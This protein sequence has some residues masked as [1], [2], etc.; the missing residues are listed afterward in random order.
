MTTR[1]T[2][3]TLAIAALLVLLLPRW[4]PCG[5]PGG[6][7]ARPG[8]LATTCTPYEVE[9]MVVYLLELVVDRNLGPRYATGEECH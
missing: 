7:C 2:Q 1:G 5:Y 6:A 3:I 4:V 9:P 8:I